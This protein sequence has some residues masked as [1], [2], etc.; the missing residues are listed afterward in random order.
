[1]D[2]DIVSGRN[3]SKEHPSDLE[4]GV[5]V[6]KKFLDE[7]GITDP[8]GKTIEFD[9]YFKPKII[10]IVEDLHF[11]SLRMEIKPMAF[12][13]FP[14]WSFREVLVKIKPDNVSATVDFIENKWKQIVPDLPF[15]FAFLNEL[16]ED[17]YRSEDNWK[18]IIQYSTFF[19]ITIACLGLFG[20]TS[21]SIARRTREM[22][23]RKVLGASAS[24]IVNQFNREYIYLILISNVISLPAA[25]RI[26][27][28]WLQTFAY[29]IELGILLFVVSALIVMILSVL[30]IG[31]LSF[32]AAYSNPVDTLR[33]E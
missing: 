25:Y 27:Q 3:F 5:I 2:I 24:G 10:G 30:T 29:K 9:D 14:R 18:A 16:L 13:I 22:G 7:F 31:I 23:I 6:N 19:A 17:Q 11:E 32:K 28:N 8:I 33:Y 15:E 4:D 26:M 12:H 1:M 21:L 20:M